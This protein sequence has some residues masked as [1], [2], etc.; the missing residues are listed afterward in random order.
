MTG[1]TPV[2]VANLSE[3]RADDE[4]LALEALNRFE[5]GEEKLVFVFDGVA[6][7]FLKL[8]GPCEKLLGLK[9]EQ[10]LTDPQAVRASIDA[11]DWATASAMRDDIDRFGSI[12]LPMHAK[13][14]DG[15]RR[16]LRVSLMKLEFPGRTLI[17][18]SVGEVES[19]VEKHDSPGVLRAAMEESNVGVAVTDSKGCFLYLNREHVAL[20]GYDSMEELLGKSWQ[21]L[22][23]EE[24]ALQIEQVVFPKLQATG[25]WRGM[26]QAKRKDGSL[27]HEALSLS[28]L[29]SGGLV[30]SCQDVTAQV[31]MTER[32]ERSEAM[33]RIFLHTLPTGV[34][35]RNLMGKYEFVNSATWAFLGL[36]HED[37]S[38]LETISA[39]LSQ[40]SLFAPWAVA[41]ERVSATGIEERFDF[42][43][44][45]G[46][47]DFV[48]DVQKLPLRL[49]S[50]GVTH[51][52]TLFN[53][54]T[55]ARRM[56][57]ESEETAR[58]R[59][60][61]NVI[62]REFV[63]MVSHE[64]RTPLTAIQG[65]QYLMSKRA[66]ELA[67]SIPT[68]FK[69]WLELQKQALGTLKELVDQV[70]LLNRI[71][72]LSSVVPQL[73]PLKAFFKRVLDGLLASLVTPRIAF[74]PTL[75]DEFT[76]LI[77]E[78]QI[79]ALVEN[80]ISNGLKYSSDVVT[81]RVG[82]DGQDWWMEVSD[83]GRGIPAADQK[84]LF[85]PFY[86]ASNVGNVTGTGL[87]LAIVQ[88]CAAFHKASVA[89][90]SREGAGTSFTVRF[91]QKFSGPSMS[92]PDLEPNPLPSPI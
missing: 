17:A 39:C 18:G 76:A 9:R 6:R 74:E 65:L 88:R 63:S 3:P 62:Q 15:R 85:R 71:E 48:L 84:K 59:S 60:E 24:V 16:R 56:E 38:E 72:H 27:F 66:G 5:E 78:S 67:E 53:D 12:V 46:G 28:F 91:P 61:I 75:P 29:Q 13:G 2:I 77:D 54:V 41:D 64:F 68:D 30:C 80:L 23:P 33:F 20:F 22:Y 69:R 35:V 45:W 44:N 36:A 40:N 10:I 7:R 57:A 8:C 83:R 14:A 19:G 79:R 51:V 55:E 31:S 11:F 70:L 90:E 92:R 49:S 21:I 25:Q 86:R 34:T 43:L 37:Q 42:R 52:C 89:V 26:L 58:R 47:R 81:L 73:V 32:M 82:I 4:T 50:A 1:T 87:G